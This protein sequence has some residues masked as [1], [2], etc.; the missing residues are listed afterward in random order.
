M[1]SWSFNRGFPHVDVLKPALF[2]ALCLL[3]FVPL[4]SSL[5]GDAPA[6]PSDISDQCAMCHEDKAANL[7]GT[8]HALPGK[9]KAKGP[10]IK[11]FCQDCHLR[12]EKHL[13]IEVSRLRAGRAICRQRRC[14]QLA[15]SVILPDT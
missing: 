7:Q 10:G 1:G 2:V 11:V 3:M 8:P 6:S 15:P 13:E 12:P 4:A 9:Y 5:Q 14:L